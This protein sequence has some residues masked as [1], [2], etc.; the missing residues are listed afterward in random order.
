MAS[1][2]EGKRPREPHQSWRA[3]KQAAEDETLL[4]LSTLLQTL[5]GLNVTVELRDDT[6]VRGLLNAVDNR[7][8]K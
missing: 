4:T 1:A 8:M 6:V 5:V 7:T 3:R 2:A